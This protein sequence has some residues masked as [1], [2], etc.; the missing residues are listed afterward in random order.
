[1]TGAVGKII[2]IT[3]YPVKSFA[4]ESLQSCEIDTYGLFGDRFCAFYDETKQGWDSFFTARD[5]PVM[6]SYQAQ[7]IED[8]VR[9]TSPDGR[10]FRWDQQLLEEIQCYTTQKLSMKSYK[11]P[12]PE[13]PELMSVDLASVLIITDAALNR[14]EEIWGKRLD[15]RRFRANLIV[16][17]DEAALQENEWIGKRLAMGTAQL[18]V[19]QYCE[20]CSMITLDPDTL[21]RDTTL[22]RKV[23]EVMGVNFGLY[24]S[25]KQ[26]GCIQVGD[27]VYIMD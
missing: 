7:L 16:S 27:N 18:E 21:E 22:L 9:I 17:V 2:G 11:S 4:G 20:R 1:M 25:V 15:P 14:L 10:V 6:L 12:N 23:R 8:E 3:R 26:T 19:N 13:A 5:L 24:A